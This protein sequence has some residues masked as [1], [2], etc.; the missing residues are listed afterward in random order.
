MFKIKTMG[1]Y[2][3]LY[4]KTDI[5]LLGDVFEERIDMCLE[6]YALDPCHYFGSPGLSSEAMLKMTKIKLELISDLCLYF[7]KKK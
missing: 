3:D 5:L 7:F 6:Y 1:D 2:H 4:L